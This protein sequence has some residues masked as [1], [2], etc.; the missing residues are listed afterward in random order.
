ML[1]IVSSKRVALRFGLMVHLMILEP[2]RH[3]QNKVCVCL[4][5]HFY[6]F[7]VFHVHT[8]IKIKNVGSDQLTL[9]PETESKLDLRLNK[10]KSVWNVF[11]LWSLQ[12]Q[13]IL[14]PIF[15]LSLA[16]DKNSDIIL[17]WQEGKTLIYHLNLWLWHVW[18]AI[19]GQHP[20]L[21]GGLTWWCHAAEQTEAAAE[22]VIAGSRHLVLTSAIKFKEGKFLPVNK[23]RC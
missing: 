21:K 13:Q 19:M 7:P 12:I 22:V 9:A 23:S 1:Y 8:I 6:N 11:V 18:G 10:L 17:S 2:P 15:W 5:L 16:S 4:C 20:L 14:L 3:L